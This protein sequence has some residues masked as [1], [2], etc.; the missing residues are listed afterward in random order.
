M[1][2]RS[3]TGSRFRSWVWALVVLGALAL[4]LGAVGVAL[5]EADGSGDLALAAKV[6]LSGDG[7]SALCEVEVSNSAGGRERLDALRVALPQGVRYVGVAAGSEVA[8]E[9]RRD[10]DSLIW[11]GPWTLGPG[12]DLSLRFAL[13]AED[14]APDSG[15]A[16]QVL[17]DEGVI[18]EV[19][20]EV[21]AA[22]EAGS[23]AAA[24]GVVP[25]GPSDNISVTKS[26]NKTSVY[27]RSPVE[28]TVVFTNTDGSDDIL[29]AITDT[30]PSGV[31]FVAMS[32]GS[33]V[34]NEWD[35]DGNRV[36]PTVVGQKVIWTPTVTNPLTVPGLGTLTMKY[37]VW[38]P[39]RNQPATLENEVEAVN[40]DAEKV[41][42]DSA[43]FNVVLHEIYMP[44][45]ARNHHVTP[46][47]LLQHNFDTGDSGWTDFTNY[48]RLDDSQWYWQNNV[49][50]SGGGLRHNHCL[51]AS[52]CERGAEDAVTMY[53][54]DDSQ[55]NDPQDWT[56]Y[57][58]TAKVRLIEGDW[59]GLWFRGTYISEDQ[60]TG[61]Y[62]GGYY[63]GIKFH[64]GGKVALWKL[65]NYGGIPGYFSDPA[66]IQVE[67]QSINDGQWYTLKVEVR[68]NHIQC[69]V[70]GTEVF[71]VYDSDWSHGTIGFMGYVMDDA[72]FDNVLVEPLY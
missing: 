67:P 51:G 53:L 36:N 39:W 62:V 48:W 49:G 27:P 29:T 28:Y 17:S 54:A 41:G 22:P 3:D 15:W 21:R 26:A 52:S 72:R 45:A 70:D 37:L 69:F 57:R 64:G 6:S 32:A 60:P 33:D 65:K 63:F 55:G 2:Y 47:Y 59:A 46:P 30:L 4:T 66:E 44:Y 24:G 58:Y 18:R 35:G 42:P 16:V 40:D 34:G 50:Y 8:G 43:S 38:V 5:G 25:L 14:G 71:N 9:P 23:L 12:D 11:E 31:Y 13:F 61:R 7:S 10:G 1:G 56:D 19:E 68:G 20:A